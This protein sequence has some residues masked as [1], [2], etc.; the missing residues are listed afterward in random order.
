MKFIL[1]IATLQTGG[2]ERQTVKLANSLAGLGHSVLLL[3]NTRGA[4]LEFLVDYNSGL[5]Q[6]KTLFASVNPGRF[7]KLLQMAF[8]SIKL[9]NQISDFNPGIVYSSLYASN[10]AAAMALLGV[11]E[12]PVLAWSIRS[13]KPKKKLLIQLWF[14]LCKSL[15]R[16]VDLVV[17]NSSAGLESHRRFGFHLNRTHLFPN[18]IDTSLFVPGKP[19][20][21]L[22]RVGV[23][24]RIDRTKDLELALSAYAIARASTELTSLIIAGPISDKNY[25]DELKRCIV[26]LGIE[27]K[28]KWV[29]SVSG[30]ELV[31]LYQGLDILLNTST[32]EGFSNVLCE[33]MC[34]NVR[35]VAADV[36]DSK[37]IV[38][39]T[40]EVVEGRDA[41]QY[42]ASLVKL[43]SACSSKEN[44]PRD[45]IL[46]LFPE[47][48]LVKNFT[49]EL[50][51]LVKLKNLKAEN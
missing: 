33:A 1:Y 28:V 10:A 7:A 32:T 47:S 3:T 6:R 27:D 45:R 50:E 4:E 25:L 13:E 2:A 24:G 41:A 12:K 49:A 40:G 14:L 38:G 17:S 34:C 8:A 39:D 23:V 30:E 21:S 22:V 42:A 16:R 51:T 29:G 37:V 36:G 48:E 15:S 11:R 20:G 26:F 31:H 18:I 9:R 43:A 19:S 5:I 35:C 46:S 44:L